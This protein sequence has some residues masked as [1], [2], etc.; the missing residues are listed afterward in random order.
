MLYKLCNK[1]DNAADIKY[2]IIK[3][4]FLLMSNNNKYSDE[5]VNDIVYMIKKS[6]YH[7]FLL[8]SFY[9]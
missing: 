7:I 3:K 9:I 4:I 8:R 2:M 6:K 1:K 5:K